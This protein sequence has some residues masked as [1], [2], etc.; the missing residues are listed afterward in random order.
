MGH[1]ISI[2]PVELTIDSNWFALSK[3]TAEGNGPNFKKV[4][5]TCSLNIAIL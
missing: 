2:E 1:A 3:Y 5:P 4:D